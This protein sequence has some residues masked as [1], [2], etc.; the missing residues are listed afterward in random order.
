ML[1]SECGRAELHAG[2]RSVARHLTSGR[3]SGRRRWRARSV[4]TSSLHRCADRWVLTVP[5]LMN[6]RAPMSG[7]YSGRRRSGVRPPARVGVRLAQPPEGLLRVPRVR[8]YT[9]TASSRDMRCP[10]AQAERMARCKRPS[11]TGH[12]D[13]HARRRTA[14]RRIPEC[15]ARRVAGTEHARCTGGGGRNGASAS[16]LST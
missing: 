5:R 9:A 12:A 11:E 16:R 3:G 8:R 15:A 4:C 1:W 14:W 6:S 2:R 13:S 10:S 7:V